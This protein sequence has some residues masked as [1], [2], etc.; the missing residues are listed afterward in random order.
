MSVPILIV[1]DEPELLSAFQAY[2]NIKGF[3]TDI[4]TD[5]KV[6]LERILE[7]QYPVV[8]L[9][10]VMPQL[11]GLDMLQQIKEG[12][13]EVEVVMITANSTADRVWQARK[14]GAADFLPKPFADLDLIGEVV[15]LAGE[16]ANRWLTVAHQCSIDSWLEVSTK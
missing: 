4:E 10:I 9:D 8:L 7:G 13:P 14:L 2:L 5:P 11:D 1:D 6:A 3:I 15:L 16:R 12:R